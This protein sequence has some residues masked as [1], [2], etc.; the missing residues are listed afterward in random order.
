MENNLEVGD[1]APNFDLPIDSGRTGRLSDFRGKVVVVY[2]YPKDNTPGCT[3]E[4]CNFR[5][6]FDAF[7]AKGIEVI[8]IST[9]TENSH[10]KFRNKFDLPFLLAPDNSREISKSYNVLG[11]TTAKRVTFI[12]DN[13]GKIAY[14]FGTVKPND[15]A[16][17]VLDK[18]AELGLKSK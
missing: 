11:T 13:E 3:T 18:I 14:K 2:F 15:H 1:M 16:L 7:K 4:A 6:N 10:E 5:D 9:D 12:V 8:G 17:K